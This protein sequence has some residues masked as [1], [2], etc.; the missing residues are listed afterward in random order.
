M[1]TEVNAGTGATPTV[2]RTVRPYPVREAL[3][4]WCAA[5]VSGVM[6]VIDAPGGAV[7]VV[8]GKIAYA[9]CTVAAGMERLLA[10]SGRL[11]VEAWRGAVAAG[12]AQ[13]RV[14][15][16][17]VATGLVSQAELEALSVIA[18]YDAAFFLFDL[19]A[20]AQF[21]PGA[22]HPFG[23]L[24]T[25][26][27]RQV[28]QEVDRRKRLLADAWPDAAID[29][30]A[31]LPRRRL[32]TQAVALTALQWEV[33]AGAD[34]RRSP[35]D[36]ARLLGRDTFTVMLEVRR[37]ARSGLV[38]PGRPGGS[39]AAESVATVRARA[40]ARPELVLPVPRASPERI[41]EPEPPRRTERRTEARAP[42]VLVPLPRR[43]A[44]EP[45]AFGEPDEPDE[46]GYRLIPDGRPSDLILTR[47]IA[48]LEAL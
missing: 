16:E 32:S 35:I 5:G 45:G 14:G 48:G 1:P 30:A 37:M 33:V 26:D 27:L 38:E 23:P 34:R 15:A 44:R 17:L 9:E 41:P 36:L 3:E 11:P 12:R 25:V 19:V 21:E 43:P 40:A 39:V 18:V 47:L 46:P 31:V 2:S 22:R 20:S 24:R 28:C 8:D 29:T 10:G 7:Y 6:R 13:Q 42:A 4:P